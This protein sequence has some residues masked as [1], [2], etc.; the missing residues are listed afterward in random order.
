MHWL[1]VVVA[2][3]AL[4]GVTPQ[5]FHRKITKVV[6]GDYLLYLPEGYKPDAKDRFPVLLFLHGFGERGSNLEQLKIH[7]PFK[8]IAKGRKF[9]FIVVAPQMPLTETS[10]DV[11]NLT[12]L[13]DEIESKYRVDKTREYVTGLSMGGFG[14]WALA[15]SSPTRFAAAAPICG[16]GNFLMAY[17]LKDLPIWAIHGDQDPAVPIALDQAM[18]DAVKQVGGNIQFT[19][20]KGGLHDVWTPFYEGAD[21]YDWLLQ[22]HR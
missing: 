17:Q 8:E 12:G 11:D 5:K 1:C 2:C 19:I 14:T 7:G 20:I 9:P 16:G 18:V 6:S 13:L 15:A 22:H 3:L 4:Q 21:L 10:W